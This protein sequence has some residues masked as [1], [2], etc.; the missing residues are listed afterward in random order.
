MEAVK[1]LGALALGAC[2]CGLP[3]AA[4][5]QSADPLEGVAVGAIRVVGLQR[6]DASVVEAHLVSRVGQ[7]FHRADL[8][9]DRRALDELRLFTS[10]T[11]EPILEANAVVIVVTVTETLRL[12]PTLLMRVTDENGVSVG[13]G[14]RGINLFGGGT[15]TSVGALFGG[16]TS[17]TGAVEAPTITP[18]TWRWRAGFRFTSRD[19]VLYS[20]DEH[21]TALSLR[22][23]RNFTHGLRLGAV[24]DLLVVDTAGSSAALSPD[25]TDVIASAGGFVTFDTLDSTTNP[26]R[27]TWAEAQ[28]EHLGVDAS[29]WTVTFDG[30]RFQ[31]LSD[32]HGLGVFALATVQTGVVGETLPE[33]LQFALGG[34]NSIRGWS[35]GS[36]QGRNQFIGGFEYAFVALPVQYFRVQGMNLYGGLQV[37]AFADFGLAWDRR[38]DFSLQSSITG[39]GVGL[40]LLV[41]FVD[42]LRLDLAWGQPGLGPVVCFGVNL[43]ATRQRQRVR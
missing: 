29:S 9:Q 14:L 6:L 15:L 23:A 4:S 26:R 28:I 39:Y 13:G 10:E 43:K 25:G 2:L 34:A 30:R 8:A 36:R 18:G 21:S 40:R 20:F 32:R 19:N 3:H 1:R 17:V 27:G 5:A 7:P 38:A 24:A 16:E 37:V 11:V 12:L 41:P 31:P 35:L 42:L 33:Y 22:V